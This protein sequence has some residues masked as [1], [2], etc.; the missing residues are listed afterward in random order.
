MSVYL[1]A[2]LQIRENFH[3]G[4]IKAYQAE[5]NKTTGNLNDTAISSFSRAL[6]ADQ[7]A[8]AVFT[9]VQMRD[10]CP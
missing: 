6:P 10:A 3:F 8:A 1:T 5:G 4:L 2:Q 9:Q 7:P